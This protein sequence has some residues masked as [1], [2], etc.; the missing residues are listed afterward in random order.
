MAKSD[1]VAKTLAAHEK[2]LARLEA[3]FSK[4]KPVVKTSKTSPPR[5]PVGYI[6]ALQE[7]GFFKTERS[8]GDIRN[9]LEE[10]GHIYTLAN[11]S[12]ALLSLV[13][14][15]KRVLRRIRKAGKWKYVN[16]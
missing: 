7:E 10:E 4:S 9:K 5:G 3:L 1:V 14:R 2:R 13:Q 15:Q 12:P 11:L 6:T 8:I 16:P